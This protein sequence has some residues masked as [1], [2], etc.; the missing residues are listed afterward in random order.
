MPGNTA[1]RAPGV[2]ASVPCHEAIIEA[3]S[4][5]IGLP[6]DALRETNMYADGDVTPTVCGGITLGQN[7]FAWHIP[8]MW[9]QCK[10]QWK[11]AE[12]RAAITKFN[13]ANRWRKRGLSMLPVK[14]NIDTTYYHM[15][16]SV[17]IFGTDGTVH[18]VHGG[19]ELGQGIHTKVAQAVAYAL[20]CPLDQVTIGDT[21]TL[22]APN[23]N[24]TGGSGGSESCVRSVLDACAKLNKVLEPY[25]ADDWAATITAASKDN[26][27]LH[28][29]GWEA[30]SAAEQHNKLFDYATQGVGCIEVE[31]DALTGEIAIM[32]ADILMDQGCPLNPLIDLGQVEGGFM[33]ALGYYLTEEVLYSPTT[34]TQLSLGTW[35]YKPPAVA[36]IPIEFNVSFV[37]QSPNQRWAAVTCRYMPLHAVACHDMTLHAVACHDMPLHARG[38]PPPSPPQP[39]QQDAR[40]L[41]LLC[42]QP[43]PARAPRCFCSCAWQ[44]ERRPGFQGFC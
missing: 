42:A 29:A 2:I 39:P 16:S 23:S 35:Q 14:Y 18:V 6:A 10:T 21:S 19:C 36:D 34:G 30:V 22:E 27:A 26:A 32:R 8:A 15:S 5:A 1:V 25:R 13:G 4:E 43:S 44:P 38:G 31:L 40:T 24:G 17:R 20:R 41:A 33:M 28:A 3:V 7:G 9:A 37:A 11:V 12:R